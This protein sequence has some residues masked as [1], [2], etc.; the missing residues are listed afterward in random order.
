MLSLRLLGPVSLQ[1]DGQHMPLPTHKAQALLLLLA[2]GGPS[3]RARLAAWLWPQADDSAGRRN[4]R[5][6]LARLRDAGAGDA[7]RSQGEVLSLAPAVQC[8]ALDFAALADAGQCAA[9]LVLWRGPLADGLQTGATEAFD[10]WLAGERQRLASRRR[11]LLAAEA[12]AAEAAG[13]LPRAQ[14]TVQQLLADDPLQEH[15]HRQAMRLHAAAGNRSAALAQHVRCRDI[16]VRELGLAPSAE[17]DEL[18]A[19]IRAGLGVASAPVVAAPAA[20]APTPALT[21]SATTTTGTT[22]EVDGVAW[23][24][25]LPLTGRD[26]AWQAL[27]AAWQAQQLVVIEGEAGVGKTRLA[28]DFAASR[29]AYA[30]AQCRRSDSGVPY[31]SFTRLLR[32]LAGQSLA[33]AGLPD[34]VRL[35]LAHVLPELG[36]GAQRIGSAEEQRRFCEACATAWQLLTNGIFDTVVLDDWHLADDASRALLGFIAEQRRDGTA[37]SPVREIHVQRPEWPSADAAA[38]QRAAQQAAGALVLRL[39]PLDSDSVYALVKRLSGADDPRRF[40]QRL[41]RATGGNPFFVGETLRQWLGLG[42]LGVGPDGVWQTP[43]DDATQDYAELPVPDTVRDAVIARVQRQPEAVRRL[44]EAAALAS[45]PFTA[46]LLA[47]ACALSEV[48]ALDAIDRAVAAQLLRERDGGFAFA[49]DLVQTALESALGPDRARLVHRRLALGAEAAGQDSADIARHWEAGGEPARAVAHRI[50]AAEAALALYADADAQAHWQA[51]LDD[52]PTLAQRVRILGQRWQVQAHRGDVPGLLAAVQALDAAR[53]QALAMP[54]GAPLALDAGLHAA[55]IV[56]HSQRNDDA[57]AR[58][59]ACLADPALGAVARARA[60]RVQSQVLSRL[61][62]TDEARAATEAALAAGGLAPLQQ[63]DLLHALSY[64]HF[65]AG[66]PQASLDHARRALAV[67]QGVGARRQ[68]AQAQASI[69]RALDMLDQR[70]A[71]WAAL[72]EAFAQ[73]AALRMLDLQRVVANNLANNRIN[74]GGPARAIQVI[75]EAQALAPHFTMPAMPVFY[76]GILVQAHAQLGA[77]GTALA[78][79]DEALDRAIALGETLTLADCLLMTLGLR[80]ALGDAPGVHRLLQ[81]TAGRS[82]DGLGYFGTK[83]ALVLADHD[84]QQGRPDAARARLAGIGPVEALRIPPDRA[85]ARLCLARQALADGDPQAALERLAPLADQMLYTEV[86]AR[87]CALRLA[88]LNRLGRSDPPALAL[89]DAA[90]ADGADGRCLPALDRLALLRARRQAAHL[91]GDADAAG[92]LAAAAQQ[93]Q[94]QLA[95]SL[96]PWQALAPALGEAPAPG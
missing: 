11:Q 84:L 15:L 17:T 76:L 8:D 83:V 37:A 21:T 70:E 59:E 62:R 73:A 24:A 53:D 61:G 4:L 80:S 19:R 82:L 12:A 77:L 58:I 88:A 29:G 85:A 54:D 35:E 86:E 51:A 92:R 38:Q 26:A 28:R 5:R 45:E 78:L 79:A 22:T 3:H 64:T 74:H 31:A 30:L 6:E 96:G 57:L 87:S 10:D 44:L 32:G 48:E 16:L 20:A 56:A 63:G 40:A 72:E 34:W 52:Q 94:Q 66:S 41:D 42:L 89:A 81:A 91:A 7:L 43:F 13:D 23:P 33:Q 55:E 47:G 75:T 49:H 71:A 95:A 27:Q 36:P 69:G 46:T 65:L 50:A 39:G 93:L 90:L 9:A 60:L 18:A 68:M 2:L 25:E 1:Q 67:W 14:D